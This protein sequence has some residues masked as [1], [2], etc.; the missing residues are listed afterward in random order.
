MRHRKKTQ[1]LGRTASH[2]KATLRNIATALILHHQIRTTLAK[3]KA[4]RSY[5]EK[6][7]TTS[8]QDTVHARRQIFKFL[9][10]RTLIKKMFD[11]IAPAFADKKGGYTRIV[12]LGRRIGDG[13]EMAVLQLVGFEA[14]IIEEQETK[15]KKRK[16]KAAKKKAEEAEEMEAAEE[17]K[18]EPETEKKELKKAKEKAEKEEKKEPKKKAQKKEPAKAEEQA[19]KKPA[20]KKK[21][22]KKEKIESKE[23]APQKEITGKKKEEERPRDK[24]EEK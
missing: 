17:T 24:D 9:Q 5:I 3:A 7:I 22:D 8:K 14:M 16:E 19:E 13:A 12:K 18:E 21:V 11:E 23:K 6:L 2:R 20:E 1:K 10:N 4:A 15:K